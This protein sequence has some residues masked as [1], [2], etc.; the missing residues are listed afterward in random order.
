MKWLGSH[1]SFVMETFF[2][3]SGSITATQRLFRTHFKLGRHDP[4]LLIEAEIFSNF[5][6]YE[7]SNQYLIARDDA[8]PL[9]T[10]PSLL[11]VPNC[12]LKTFLSKPIK[13]V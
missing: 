6:T 11:S 2:T 8:G 9:Y 12:H 7:G 4:V 10:P 3:N 1:R 13:S 5:S